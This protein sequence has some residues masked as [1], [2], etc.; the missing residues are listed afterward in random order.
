M[1]GQ[2]LLSFELVESQ[3]GAI[4]QY[5]STFYKIISCN[6]RNAT[7]GSKMG[8]KSF[9]ILFKPLNFLTFERQKITQGKYEKCFSTLEF[10]QGRS[11]DPT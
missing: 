7:K 9:R 3:D 5:C 11:D 4:W 1:S 8:V 2:G 6:S 10:G